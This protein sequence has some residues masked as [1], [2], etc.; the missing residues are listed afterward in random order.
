MLKE[1]VD[2]G[3]VSNELASVFTFKGLS[4]FY[5]E[6]ILE[7][8]GKEF[9]FKP[10]KTIQSIN[11]R[12]KYLE[13]GVH[14]GK[15]GSTLY[16]F[17]T[18]FIVTKSEITKEKKKLLKKFDN[19]LKEI[20]KV[21]KLNNEI[22]EKNFLKKLSS[23]IVDNIDSIL[24]LANL[25][26]LKANEEK[27]KKSETIAI[28]L[29][30]KQNDKTYYIS[31][32]K[33]IFKKFEEIE[34]SNISEEVYHGSGKLKQRVIGNCNILNIETELYS[35]SGSFYY[36]YST[37]KVNVKYDLKDDKNL[38][39]LSKEAYI[40]FMIG[41]TYLES[42]HE[43]Y[44]MG[45]KSYITATSLSDNALNEFQNDV[46]LSKNNFK[47]FLDLVKDN[48]SN[49]KEILL[50]FYFFEPAKTGGGKE[51][52]EFIKDVI[53]SYLV[54]TSKLFDG[55]LKEFFEK[56]FNH[57]F[58]NFYWQNHIYQIYN[59][60][61]YKKF[62]TSLFRK[63][64]LGDKIDCDNLILLMNEKMQY[65][66]SKRNMK[67]AYIYIPKKENY[68]F[69]NWI[70]KL[71][72]GELKMS[73]EEKSQKLFE[74]KTYE[75]KLSNFLSTG[76]LVK[77]S[78]SMRIGV[79]LGLSID[80]LSWSINNY[81]KKVLSF[82]RKRVERN[83]LNS[84]Q[85]FINEIFAKTKFHSF[86]G[87]QSVNS[88]LATLEMLNLSDSSFNKDEFIF[89]LFLGNGLYTNIKSEKDPIKPNEDE[90]NKGENNE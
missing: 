52:I 31:S 53:P 5:V 8:D 2:I 29:K 81:D 86:D 75:E 77:D 72:K 13:F 34:F 4:N 25:G 50:N 68:I 61:E 23:K 1:I 65:D 6:I 22:E 45:M 71:N 79:C 54:E 48:L 70:D 7:W 28:V 51:I 69:L 76:N 16:F 42:F 84:L 82:V 59:K 87:L 63:I 60:N 10:N 15:K 20:E 90:K 39:L 73:E 62:R 37:D 83:S 67:G 9:K 35:P 38:F 17:P 14:R 44:F 66:V 74:G 33:S 56:Q 64:A 78:A 58:T 57:D 41:K 46:R 3:K 47:G 55:S 89:G 21:Y 32:Q 88:R 43:F 12:E 36:P 80:I 24:D 27:N 30:F 85:S 26:L 11:D 18:S 40:N 49:R 19:G